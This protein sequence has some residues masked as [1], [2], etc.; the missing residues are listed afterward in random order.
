[1]ARN[2]RHGTIQKYI[3]LPTLQKHICSPMYIHATKHSYIS[4]LFALT[5]NVYIYIHIHTCAY[6]CVVLHSVTMAPSFTPV[7]IRSGMTTWFWTGDRSSC[8]GVG[9]GGS[10]ERG[11]A[12]TTCIC[13]CVCIYIYMCVCVYEPFWHTL[14]VN[15]Y[16]A[17]T[18]DRLDLSLNGI[19]AQSKLAWC[20]LFDHYTRGLPSENHLQQVFTDQR[21]YNVYTHI[22]IMCMFDHYVSMWADSLPCED[23]LYSNLFSD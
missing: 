10:A 4:A 12:L 19:W 22:C 17:C 3:C 11:T 1:M 23:Q 13:V 6:Y 7:T 14:Q 9:F 15:T 16:E 18:R 20:G 21:M 5:H 2:Y 8:S